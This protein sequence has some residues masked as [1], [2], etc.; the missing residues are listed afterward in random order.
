MQAICKCSITT[1]TT[2]NM[3]TIRKLLVAMTSVRLNY[4]T[5]GV[6]MNKDKTHMKLLFS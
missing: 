5:K 4:F 1:T 2:T 6:A 3:I